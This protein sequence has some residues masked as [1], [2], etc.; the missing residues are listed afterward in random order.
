MIRKFAG[1]PISKSLPTQKKVAAKSKIAK[2]SPATTKPSRNVSYESSLIDS[3]AT[4][5][6]KSKKPKERLDT[7][8][9]PAV[10]Q[11]RSEIAQAMAPI[12]T[13]FQEALSRMLYSSSFYVNFVGFEIIFIFYSVVFLVVVVL[14]C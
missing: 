12:D 7:P 1:K 11:E 14:S 13:Q 5:K 2:T 4:S 8:R 3:L 9:E 10:S 6:K